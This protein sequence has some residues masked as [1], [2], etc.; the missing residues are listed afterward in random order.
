MKILYLD[1]VGGLS[2]DMFAGALVD[3]GVPLD[4]LQERLRQVG[5]EDVTVSASKEHRHQIAGVRFSVHKRDGAT[6]DTGVA[7]TAAFKEGGAHTGWSDIDAR[8]ASSSMPAGSVERA[9]RIFRILAEAEGAVHAVPPEKVQFHE[10]GAWDSIADIVCAAAGIEY[11]GIER[12]WVSPVPV[13]GGTVRTAHGTMPVPAPA[14]LRLL[15]GFPVVHGGP[16]YERTTPTGAAILAA[17]AQPAPEA[18]TY[19]PE[20]IGIGL[21]KT[22]RP[23]VANLARAVMGS[24]PDPA[25]DPMA[26]LIYER[27]ELAAANVDDANPEW[28]GFTMERLFAAGALDVVWVPIQMKKQRP[29]TQLQVLYPPKL[30]AAVLEVLFSEGT[31]LGVRFQS[32]ERAILPRE[33]ISVGSPWGPIAGK[34]AQFGGRARFSPEFESCR[35]IALQHHIPLPEVYRAAQSAYE[36]EHPA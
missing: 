27:I 34:V 32:W 23:E 35:A 26:G 22:D 25:P 16:A 15:Q 11:L 14:T 30:R 17:L 13:G 7:V 21:G 5:L 10:V 36:A 3:L 20:R 12:I 24:S 19:V 33:A 28:T 8:L 29:G 2:G 9:R 31:T 1:L 6:P 4:L 18:M